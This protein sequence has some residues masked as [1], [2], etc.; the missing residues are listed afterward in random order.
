MPV[1][2]A[3]AKWKGDLPKGT[4][5]VGT[6]SGVLDAPYSFGSRFEEATGTN[7]E[8]LVGAAHAAC[9]SMFLSAILAKD[10]HDPRSV[11][12]TARVHLTK[13]DEG[14]SITRIDLESEATVPGIEDADFQ[15]YVQAA[16]KGC[17]I[18]N[19]L[20]S[21]PIEVEARLT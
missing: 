1:R 11:R 18:S 7:P 6:E 17:P 16:K 8:E 19:A 4:G 21:V 10:G 13:G 20:A 15:E 5:T 2:T 9:Y 14:F 12:T 3:S